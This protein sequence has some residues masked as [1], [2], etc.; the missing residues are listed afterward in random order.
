MTSYNDI[1]DS[2]D[3][4]MTSQEILDSL[5]TTT[6]YAIS[7]ANLE[8]YLDFQSLA[9]RN[10]ITGSWQGT[11][12][13]VMEAGGELGAGLSALFSHMNKPHSAEI[14]SHEPAWAAMMN[15]LLGGL[16]L[17]G[18][19]TAD[20]ADSIVALGGGHVHADTTVDA[21]DSMVS[22]HNDSLA[23]AANDSRYN[24][25]YNT[26]ISPLM[27]TVSTDEEWTAAL[28]AMSQAWAA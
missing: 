20:Q 1:K 2:V 28:L 8:N 7:I 22:D 3:A 10:A 24:E 6:R 25:L 12:V 5:P 21:I 14:S 11:L 9:N 13:T 23:A 17:G 4:G 18:V 27:G 15:S 26:H 16:H 19:I